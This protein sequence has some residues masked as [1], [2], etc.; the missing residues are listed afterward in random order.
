MK[1]PLHEI[2]RSIYYYTLGEVKNETPSVSIQHSPLQFILIGLILILPFM[3]NAT[4]VVGGGITYHQME[5]NQYLLTVRLYGD[6]SPGTANLPNN[7]DIECRRGNGTLP[8]TSV[9]NLPRIQRDTL[10]PETPA[11]AF[12]PGVCVEEAI[13][14]DIINLAP[15]AGGYHLYYTICCRN[16]T[17][18]NIQN[19]LNARETFYAYV[20]DNDIHIENSSP[21]FSDIPPVYVCEGYDLNL[22]FGATDADGDSLVYYFYTP[23]DGNAGPGITYGAGA[24]PNNINI[25]PV[26]WNAGFGAND[27]LDPTPG[28]LP[29]ITIDANGI[30]N[31]TP[32]AAGQYVVGVMV[33]EYRD[34]VLIGRITRD[35]QFNVL[36][37]PPPATPGIDVADICTGLNIDFSNVSGLGATDFWWDF[38]TGNPADTSTAFEP[39][40]N[41]AD[42]GTYTVTL[43]VDKGTNCSD[44]ATYELTIMNLVQFNLNT[45]SV[46]CN[47]NGDG[48]A[49]VN[50]EDPTYL[51]DWST[52]QTGTSVNNLAP[53]NY[54]VHA[55]NA[56]GCVDTQFFAIDEPDV[57]TVQYNPT[58]PL[59]NGDQNGSL[60]A[61]ANGGTAPFNYF[62]TYQAFN[63]NLLNGI[64][65]GNY[66]VEITDNNGC[67]LTDITFLNEPTQMSVTVTGQSDASCNGLADGW[68]EVGINGG[69]MPYAI[70]WLTLANDSTYMDNLTAGN[71]VAEIHDQ[72][73]C[74]ENVVV[75][76]TEPDTFTVDIVIID[77]ET[78]TA[79][80]GSAFA[81]V[82]GGIGN[83]SF[84]WTPGAYTNDF[85]SGLS[86]GPISVTV[87]DENGCTDDDFAMLVNNP[88]GTAGIGNFS[89]VTCA[90]GSNGSVE[91]NM[92]GGTAP[93]NYSWSCACPDNSIADGLSAGNYWVAVTDHHGCVDSLYF[94]MTELPELMISEEDVTMPLCFGDENG[95]AE[96]SATGGTTPYVFE[97]SSD[98]VQNGTIAT[99]LG[100]GTYTVTVTDSNDCFKSIDIAIVQPDS[101]YVIGESISNVICYG[102]SA[103]VATA[104]AYGGTTP[105]DYYWPSENLHQQTIDNLVAGFYQLELTDSN[106]CQTHTVV[107]II[108][109]DFVTAAVVFDSVICP[110]EI[111][112]F[113]VATNGMNNLY[114]Y[115]W[116][117]DEQFQA[118]GN[119]FSM[120]VTDSV[121][122]SIELVSQVNCPSIED[123]AD[124]NPIHI[125]PGAV[126]AYATPDTICYGAQAILNADLIDSSY[127]TDIFWNVEDLTG[128]GPHSVKP[129]I[130]QYYAVTIENMC[131]EQQT[132][133]VLINVFM[134][135]GT[136]IFADG[137][138]ACEYVDA[139]FGYTY[140]DNGYNLTHT[141]WTINGVDYNEANPIVHMDYS[142][143]VNAWLYLSFDNGCTFKYQDQIGITVWERPDANFYYNPDPAVVA[144][145][146]EFV[147]ISQG[148]PQAWEYYVD[149]Q[150]ISD[151]ERPVYVFEKQGWY[152]VTQIITNENGCRDTMEHQ[153]EVIGD[154]QVY[155]PNAFTPDGRGA[156]NTFKPVFNNVQP[157]KYQ[158][159]IYN[160]WGEVVFE[161]YDLEEA[162]DGTYMGDFVK[163][164]VYVWKIVLTDNRGERHE[165]T[166]HV[167]L[168]R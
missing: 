34:G 114:D 90:D 75:N 96:V 122:V 102:D 48:A 150:Y 166:G 59:C 33:D 88:T 23:F 41:Y 116:Y 113:Y 35:F 137:T 84:L 139:W 107:E 119:T 43:I 16:G 14:Q 70:D 152:T 95:S 126:Q 73:N 99:N 76:I 121:E 92:T 134:P 79:G 108:E 135:P 164:G 85:I 51:Y 125:V 106:G 19:P 72:N 13:Y 159:L 133:S 45:D 22:N 82:N 49:Q 15:G 11:C 58:Q 60:E 24:P 7:V 128:L 167:T 144:E 147:D 40:F 77:E 81:D 94:T 55:T 138:A 50:A 149:G 2:F 18:A 156:N 10:S 66:Q 67:Q 118:T 1:T 140:D 39:A 32:T 87:Q 97:W 83:I 86:A 25:S 46:T 57:L 161:A 64:G 111:V 142:A 141:A 130:S 31:G 5:G 145:Q 91:I 151:E 117:V 54:W 98:P 101:L 115:H 105:Y 26:T 69:T 8:P 104:Q 74:Q 163:D 42:E 6:C 158:F 146:T 120:A 37:C 129:E 89:P 165:Y 124:V 52:T 62:W 160:R 162:W 27:P 36:N 20:P 80:N 17:I 38:G 30:I 29:G 153:V 12:D 93:F 53:G 63:G 168:L 100:H 28:L 136:D 47:G 103:G 148:N 3:A 157:N 71:Y 132:D 131:G 110:G 4:H 44:T 9:F 123:S 112:D 21:Q 65:T 61:I 127:I 154:F 78:C 68:V 109:Y 143:D 56:I 155:V